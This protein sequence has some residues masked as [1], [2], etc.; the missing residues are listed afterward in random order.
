MRSPPQVS[1]QRPEREL[2]SSTL[3]TYQHAVVKWK[4]AGL[5]SQN[6]RRVALGFQWSVLSEVRL[7]SLGIHKRHRGMTVTESLDVRMCVR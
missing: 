1:V 4:C 3:M 5:R 2:Q 7:A 6:A